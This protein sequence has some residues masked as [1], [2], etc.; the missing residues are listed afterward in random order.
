MTNARASNGRLVFGGKGAVKET[1][2]T[3]GAIRP[4][5][6]G[7]LD[8]DPRGQMAESRTPPS[9]RRILCLGADAD[10]S[11][12]AGPETRAAGFQ[13]V[14]C[15]DAEDAFRRFEDDEPDGIVV[16][17][18][19][20]GGASAPGFISRVRQTRLGQ[21]LPILLLSAGT[22]DLRAP[23]DALLRYDVDDYVE[24]PAPGEWLVWRMRELISGWI[25]GVVGGGDVPAEGVERPVLPLQGTELQQGSLENTDVAALF[26]SFAAAARSGKLVAMRGREVR[27]LWFRRGW[28]VFAESNVPGEEF[29]EWLL[30]RRLV[31]AEQ[32]E[33]ARATASSSERPLGVILTA[34]GAIPTRR[35][36]KESRENLAAVA[37]GLFDWNE[38][39]YYLEFVSLAEEIN[40]PAHVSLCRDSG[41]IVIDGVV[42]SYGGVRCRRLLQLAEGPLRPA[43]DGHF[44]VRTLDDPYVFENLLAQLDGR[45]TVKDMLRGP[46]FQRDDNAVAA[47]YALWVIGAVVEEAPGT[48]PGKPMARDLYA[49]RIREA[50]AEAARNSVPVRRP[51][52]PLARV[53]PANTPEPGGIQSIMSAL[54]RVSAEV[55]FEN[56]FRLFGLRQ[57]EQ[58]ARVFEEAA[59]FAAPSTRL[60]LLLA[61]S[62]LFQEGAGPDEAKRAIQAA[63][64]AVGQDPDVGDGYHWLGIAL[65]RLGYLDEA[66]LTLKRAVDLGAALAPESRAVLRSLY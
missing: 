58:A 2:N 65:I 44:V 11:K 55:A 18:D 50:V 16:D 21:I 47:L 54:E 8:A 41:S 29:G 9:V 13:M 26:F 56:G 33:A 3:L 48:A 37:R 34:D 10:L 32:M 20:E 60:L 36:L 40:A 6:D 15:S 17:L 7:R 25:L 46:P 39:H 52:A 38:G 45:R 23:T 27:Q 14:V 22:K 28:L 12:V 51:K 19:V 64:R 59:S 57:F 1:E 35:M 61:Q 30:G 42:A 62:Y 53:G 24:K 4:P 63:R 43:R 66:R 49:S 31:G 5:W